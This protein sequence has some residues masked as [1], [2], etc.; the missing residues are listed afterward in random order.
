MSTEAKLLQ[1]SVAGDR[2]AFEKIVEKYQSTVCAITFSGTGRLDLSEEL[3]QETFLNAWKNLRQLKD[4]NGFRAWICTIARNLLHNYYRSKKT[5]SFENP[6][7]LDTTATTDSSP[8]EVAIHNETQAVLEQ[9]MKRLPEK[10]RDP[11]LCFT[12]RG[13]RFVKPPLP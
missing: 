10:Y 3:A 6:E 5:V 2:N 8:P 11:L 9:A 12:A 1:A 7:R 13:N 4:F